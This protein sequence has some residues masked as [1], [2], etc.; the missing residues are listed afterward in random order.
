MDTQKTLKILFVGFG[1]VSLLIREEAHEHG[2]HL[3]ETEF[4]PEE[5]RVRL[6][7]KNHAFN[8][9]SSTPFFAGIRAMNLF[10][11]IGC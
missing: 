10:S 2:G 8:L 7:E 3:V 9:L 1:H 5:A 11:N 4:S 6:S